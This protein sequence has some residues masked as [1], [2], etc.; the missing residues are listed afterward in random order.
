M[1]S[2]IVEVRRIGTILPLNQK[3]SLPPLGQAFVRSCNANGKTGIK[4]DSYGINSPIWS[5]VE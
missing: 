2:S 3:Y 1:R 4:I 5:L